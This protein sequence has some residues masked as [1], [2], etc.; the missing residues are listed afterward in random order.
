MNP[1]TKHPTAP[2]D[3]LLRCVRCKEEER[4]KKELREHNERMRAQKP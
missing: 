4:K 1:C 2:R 3:I